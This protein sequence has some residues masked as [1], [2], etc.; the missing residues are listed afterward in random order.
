MRTVITGTIR[1]AAPHTPMGADGMPKAALLRLIVAQGIT[2][3]PLVEAFLTCGC[4]AT[5]LARIAAEQQRLKPGTRVEILG[6]G[7][8][9]AR[10]PDGELRLRMA[11]TAIVR[12]NPPTSPA[13]VP[14]EREAHPRLDFG[15]TTPAPL[16][17]AMP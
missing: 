11:H 5:G 14:D 17:A 2:R 7:I 15:V 13:H 10:L 16:M 6:D 8:K 4:G 3:A 12:A 9:L 1:Y